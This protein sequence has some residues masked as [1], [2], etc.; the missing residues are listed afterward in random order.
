M[1]IVVA[2]TLCLLATTAWSLAGGENTPTSSTRQLSTPQWLTFYNTDLSPV[3]GQQNLSNLVNSPDLG[4]LDN[5]SR[6]FGI[7][8]MWSGPWGCEVNV[9][10]VWGEPYCSGPT[11]LWKGTPYKSWGATASWEVGADWVVEQVKSRPHI[12]G[13][14]LGDEPTLFGV[15][16][17]DICAL[18]LHLKRGLLAT[19]RRDCF[20][21]FNDTPES[22]QLKH[23]L[24]PG[25]DFFSLD[26]YND[27]PATEVAQVKHAYNKVKARLRPPN[28]LEPR[29]QG[30][31]VVP[32]IFW[33]IHHGG[34]A[35]QLAPPCS[36]PGGTVCTGPDHKIDGPH[37]HNCSWSPAGTHCLISPSWLVGKMSAYWAWARADAS[38]VG[39][40]PW[41]WAD[42]P[43]MDT[44]WTRRG[45]VSLGPQ[46]RQWFA[47]IHNNISAA[48]PRPLPPPVPPPAP[49]PKPPLPTDK[50][51]WDLA[52]HGKDLTVSAGGAKATWP[53]A[54][55][56]PPGLPMPAGC[57]EA[58]RTSAPLLIPAA[59][60]VQLQAGRALVDHPFKASVGVC[61]GSGQNFTKV[62]HFHP[63][64][65]NESWMYSA[66]GT[67]VNAN[68]TVAVAPWSQPGKGV[69][70]NGDVPSANIS[71]QVVASPIAEGGETKAEFF[72]NDVFVGSMAVPSGVPLFGCAA[73]CANGTAFS[74]RSPD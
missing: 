15:S 32:G 18:S 48:G 16:Y 35:D 64:F 59:L 12:R 8:G 24:C 44:A 1:S 72:V 60:T 28:Y 39:L 74:M 6:D 69:D 56:C 30:F 73:S 33:S 5:A 45:V 67:L 46:L 68:I 7:D 38:I 14:F 57:H 53:L 49:P 17:A 50:V 13:I 23:G 58:V 51:R 27:D 2:A 10:R 55:C 41:H 19:G 70:P 29:G 22:Q 31:F 34:A 43:G 4:Q 40:N 47:M 3:R 66:T 61:T 26:S 9:S 21:Y 54:Q 20:I 25:L 52:A 62:G 63:L 36:A 65:S 42:K 71:V 11:G 37:D